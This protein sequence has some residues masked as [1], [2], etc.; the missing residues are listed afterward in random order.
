MQAHGIQIVIPARPAFWMHPV[1]WA[2]HKDRAFLWYVERLNQSEDVGKEQRATTKPCV[3]LNSCV[4]HPS[5]EQW[6]KRINT[7]SC[8]A[9]AASGIFDREEE[10]KKKEK[11]E[12]AQE[13]R[14][15]GERWGTFWRPTLLP[16]VTRE[17]LSLHLLYSADV[18]P[19]L[20]P[21]SV[22]SCTLFLVCRN[23][24]FISFWSSMHC[25]WLRMN[26]KLA[27]LN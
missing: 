11:T 13:M 23:Y 18:L 21:C 9:Q 19:P 17:L 4:I 15:E 1:G 14:R 22:R 8:Y 26:G 12:K 7:D 25:S 3:S 6:E 16:I 2:V 5:T 10:N 20:W 24:W 27:K